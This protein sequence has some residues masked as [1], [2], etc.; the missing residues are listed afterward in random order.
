MAFVKF[1]A[2]FATGT[3]ANVI[4]FYTLKN[5][6]LVLM[7]YYALGFLA[8]ALAFYFYVESPPL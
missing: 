6:I 1:N 2:A 7:F 4:L 5:W 3:M 8:L